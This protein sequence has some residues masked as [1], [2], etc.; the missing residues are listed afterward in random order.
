MIT[1]RWLG[2][3]Y[4]DRRIGLALGDPTGMLASPLE[5]V[6]AEPPKQ[7]LA[8]IAAVCRDRNVVGIVVG[9]P[10][11]LDG[12][13]TPATQKARAFAEALKSQVTV[14]VALWDERFTTVTAENALIEGGMR[15]EKRKQV[16]D[17]VAAQIL[18]QHYLDAHAAPPARDPFDEESDGGMDS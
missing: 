1:G 18:L 12:T 15:R 5:V 9:L 10:M 11:R 13:D 7:A 4:G 16:V 17:M 14:E 8:R 3:D 6:P 2:I